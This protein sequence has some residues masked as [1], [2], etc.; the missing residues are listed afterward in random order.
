MSSTSEVFAAM[1][2]AVA[3]NGGKSL[4]RKFKVMIIDAFVDLVLHFSFSPLS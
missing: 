4:Q 3:G 1:S 2:E